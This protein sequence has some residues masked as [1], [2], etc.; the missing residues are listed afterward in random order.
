MLDTVSERYR[1]Q[2]CLTKRR[3]SFISLYKSVIERSGCV[4]DL[5]LLVKFLCHCTSIDDSYFY[6]F[7][8]LKKFLCAEY[9]WI[10]TGL[11]DL[12]SM[13]SEL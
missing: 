2:G 8:M 7:R 5:L 1:S 10:T 3:G 12:V 13:S 9:R 11:L 6:D 4:L